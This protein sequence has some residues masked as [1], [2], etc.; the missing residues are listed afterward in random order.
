MEIFDK[1]RLE[2]FLHEELFKILFVK[3]YSFKLF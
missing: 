3:L 1:Q 2:T